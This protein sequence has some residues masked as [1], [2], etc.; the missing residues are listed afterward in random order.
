[1]KKLFQSITLV[2]L[3]SI[4]LVSCSKLKVSPVASVSS[5]PPSS[6]PTSTQVSPE[7]TKLIAKMQEVEKYNAYV[8]LNNI[9]T[10]SLDN[11]TNRYFEQL[12]TEESPKI[13][14]NFSFTM[15][16]F[17]STDKSNLDKYLAYSDKK[18]EFTEIDPIVV[19][20]KPVLQDLIAVLSEGHEYYD[21]K[22]YVD[23]QF[24]KSK[25]LHTE[26]LK[27]T[28]AYEPIRDEFLDAMYIMGEEQTQLTLKELQEEDQMIRYSSLQLILSAEA[29]D[30]EMADQDIAADN[31]LNLD[32][33]KYKA[34][35][36]V[37]V[38][39]MNKLNE[40][41]KDEARIKKEGIDGYTLEQFVKKV[42]ELKVSATNIVDRVNKK[43]KVDDFN[44]Q[45]SFFRETQEGTPENFAKNLGQTIN[46]YNKMINK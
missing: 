31:V 46:S 44:L 8:G 45:S 4:V 40:Y 41:A 37:F 17:S 34:K 27:I 20:L 14:K 29:I 24:A 23:D 3:A 32:L 18:P 11:V 22:G 33:E 39:N 15:L 25:E 30:D 13:G 35:Y 2:L 26:L 36:D 9:I 12:G 21:I 16:S 10:G 5:S 1:V 19:K 38:E 43:K 7:E 6:T 42:K 28:D